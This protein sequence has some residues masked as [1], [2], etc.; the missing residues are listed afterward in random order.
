MENS[1]NICLQ[2]SRPV[3]E[4]KAHDVMLLQLS[5]P[6]TVGLTYSSSRVVVPYNWFISS[7]SKQVGS[8]NLSPSDGSN[9]VMNLY[10]PYSNVI[11]LIFIIIMA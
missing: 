6:S 3:S 7:R 8:M 10:S 9:G 11:F 2:F 4:S 1:C 5:T